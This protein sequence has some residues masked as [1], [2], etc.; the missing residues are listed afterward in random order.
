MKINTEKKVKPLKKIKSLKKQYEEE[1]L[2]LKPAVR[3]QQLKNNL[4]ILAHELY[5]TKKINYS[6]YSKMQ[7][8]TYSRTTEEKLKTSFKTLKSVENEI[9]QTDSTN[10]KSKKKT[11]KDFNKKKKDDDEDKN[12][13]YNI[14]IKSKIWNIIEVKVDKPN[15]EL[16]KS[17]DNG[18]D[19]HTL[20]GIFQHTVQTYGKNN[21]IDEI[22]K[23]IDALL[24]NPYTLKVEI[25]DVHVNKEIYQPKQYR[26]EGGIRRTKWFEKNG[27]LDYKEYIQYFK[28]WNA[29][30]EYKGFNLD[31]NNDIEFECVPNALFK[32]YGT[33]KENS[34]EYLPC[35]CKGGLEYVKSCLNKNNDTVEDKVI[36]YVNP[37]DELI[38]SNEK[39]IKDIIN[40]YEYDTDYEF[41][42]ETV[43]DIKDERK[44]NEI[45]SLYKSIDECRRQKDIDNGN[46]S[47]YDDDEIITTN[48][49]QI[50][51]LQTSYNK[52]L[53]IK[54]SDF[55]NEIEY[56]LKIKSVKYEN[57][58]IS[59]TIKSLKQSNENFIKNK[60]KYKNELLTKNKKEEYKQDKK[61]YTSKDIIY[62]C[63]QHKI[64]CFGYDWK[65]QQFIT[66]KNEPINFSKNLPAFVF[67][68]NDS[69]IYLI[70][71]KSMR[72]SLLHSNDKSD[73]ISLI[74]KEAKKESKKERQIKVDIPFEEWDKDENINIYIT[75]KRVVND[76]FYKLICD[77]KI[78]N[79]GIK[80]CEHDGIIKFTY[81]NK[82]KII[83]NPDYHMVNKT[84]ENLNNRDSEIK[85][86]FK[87]QKMST[88]AME[89]LK[90]E[91]CSLPLSNMNE[92][93]DYIFN[94]EYIRNCQFNGWFTEPKSKNLSA[95]DY[96]KHYT[97]C[98][99]GKDCRFGWPV[100]CVFD[101]VKNFDGKI[102]A[103]FYYIETDNYFPFKGAGWYD[104]DLVYYAYEY[105]IIKESDIKKQYKSNLVLNVDNFKS[106]IE[107]VFKLFDDPKYAINTLIGVFGHNYKSK[108][109]H[110]F[111]QDNRLVLNELVQNKDAK[112]KYVY[113]SEFLND[114][115]ITIDIDNFNPD[116]HMKKESPLIYHVYNDKKVKSFQNYLPFFYKIYNVSAMKMHQMASKIGG[117]V[118]GVF[119]DTIIFEGQINI[120]KC[121]KNVIG[122][123]RE[124]SVKDFT[125]CTN[126]KPRESNFIKSCPKP[127][128]LTKIEEFKLIDNKGIFITGEPGTGK[129]YMCKQL[130]QE[131]L[132][133]IG[134]GNSFEVCTPTHK[135][136]LIANA[137]TIYNLFNINPVDYT[138]IKTT[139]EKL[140]DKGV[141]W[142]FIDEVSMITS[143]IWS[144][145]RDIKNIYGFTFILFGDFHQLPSVEAIHYDIVNSE[146]F[147]EICDGQ[148]LELTRNYR[149]ENDVDF[150][151]FIKDLRIIKNGGKPDFKTYNT[152]ECRK[153]LCWTNKTRKAI[154]YK[155]M[156]EEARGVEYIIINNF[157]VFVG[158]PIIC[159][160]TM[161]I[162]RTNKAQEL[163]VEWDV[164]LKNNEEF[165]VISIK[166]KKILIKND[167]LQVELNY[168][169]FSHFDLAY[170]ITTHVSQGS[171]YDFPYSIYEYQYFDKALLYTSMSRSTKKS[172]INLIDYKPEVSIGYIYKITD[173]KNKIYI[174][175]TTDYKKRWKQHEQAGEDMPLH[176]AIKDQGIENFS[177][178]VIKT[179]EF[180]DSYHL[181]IIES[182]CMDQYD[183]ITNGYNTKHS[184]CMFDLY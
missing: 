49:K 24:S 9:K 151:E 92:S 160:K 79:N 32:M 80:S 93:G 58:R 136:A 30:F 52:N 21:I 5:H 149:A 171:T 53:R 20:W 47:I 100:Y 90:N 25:L 50:K 42:V 69:H 132:K 138:Y 22:K 63:N 61:G 127:I 178:E 103:G 144:V 13:L 97:S 174:G 17:D 119:T 122:G 120:P 76:T 87:N 155:W 108:N 158:L 150:E 89:F 72:A 2:M 56:Q 33:K 139:V 85:Y 159:K 129:T 51:E 46:R 48:D 82:N 34:Y 182:C 157:K 162:K 83:F 8:L 7:T 86:E 146:V 163:K 161:T 70:N 115:N 105:K 102:E 96:N 134:N 168:Q 57:F 113:K 142:I 39:M 141:K 118:C 1:Q 106:F 6:L 18:D 128:K 14:Y 16:F 10:T 38:K 114:S 81:E 180:I 125:R 135:S 62:F 35:V 116:D 170:C 177:F 64:K 54:E 156:Q 126:T 43:D 164:E 40:Q 111:T 130:Q 98:L 67:Y 74:S 140:K 27:D 145:I 73:I 68:F 176:K 154:N 109:I 95:Y 124:T 183:S 91:F 71:D 94:C 4:I 31:M 131:I 165:E 173:S 184:V 19:V 3:I 36:D 112:V 11:L 60:D 78:Y 172:Y 169:N 147:S 99:M 37:Y 23:Y 179:V 12:I 75:E 104:A 41:D 133:G 59:E 117:N 28:A 84:I 44:K 65:M 55:E 175:S 101:E 110:H 167:R 148:M 166:D 153:S 66:N 88:L 107:D 45:L 137:M 29:S 121:N 143:K 123:I 77:G 152:T 26:Y 181:L 15:Y